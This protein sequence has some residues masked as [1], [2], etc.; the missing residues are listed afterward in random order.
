MVYRVSRIDED[1]DFGCEERP[2]DKPVTAIVTLQDESGLEHKMRTADQ[3]L[4]DREINEGDLVVICENGTI[5]RW[6]GEE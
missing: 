2:D 3:E 6:N 5:Q 4:Y 1:V